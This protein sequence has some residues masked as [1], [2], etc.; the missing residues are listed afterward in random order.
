MSVYYAQQ[1]QAVTYTISSYTNASTCPHWLYHGPVNLS[2][3]TETGHWHM[4][5]WV[6]TAVTDYLHK[7]LYTSC[8]WVC[9]A[10]FGLES[11]SPM[12]SPLQRM[13]HCCCCQS[14]TN[15]ASDITSCQDAMPQS[16]L[17]TEVSGF[18]SCSINSAEPIWL[19]CWP[20][21]LHDQ[22]LSLGKLW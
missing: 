19:P 2:R 10:M 20:A 13:T 9:H 12:I 4:V 16:L 18:S 15:K 5:Q 11:F 1:M 21:Q 22:K 6:Y 3:T 14:L 7:T 8:K 17:N